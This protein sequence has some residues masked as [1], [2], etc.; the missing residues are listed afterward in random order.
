MTE[1]QWPFRKVVAIFYELPLIATSD[2]RKNRHVQ[3][4]IPVF[5]PRR[6]LHQFGAEFNYMFSGA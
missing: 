5:V 3:Q 6:V 2:P 1:T 4:T